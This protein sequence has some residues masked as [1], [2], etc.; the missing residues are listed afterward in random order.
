MARFC[1]KSLLVAPAALVDSVLDR[2]VVCGGTKGVG[3]EEFFESGLGDDLVA[4]LNLTLLLTDTTEE[5]IPANLEIGE[6]VL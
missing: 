4:D 3:L 2:V 6:G 1:N 5:S